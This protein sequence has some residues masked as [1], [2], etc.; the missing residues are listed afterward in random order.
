[1]T[2]AKKNDNSMRWDKVSFCHKVC[3]QGLKGKTQ[4][5]NQESIDCLTPPNI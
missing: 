4:P 5:I 1:M 3:R 2:N